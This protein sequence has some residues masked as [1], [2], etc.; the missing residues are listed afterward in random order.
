[1]S[2]FRMSSINQVALSG[3]LVQNPEARQTETGCLLI[4]FPIAV[5]LHYTDA[6]GIWQK[7]ITTVPVCASGKLA[8]LVAERLHQ[9]K[10][11]FITGR[12]Q[13]RGTGLEVIAR[14]IQLLNQEMKPE[15]A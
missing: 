3:T 14:H 4:T 15:E 7:E 10:A 12:L 8:E 11:V 13:F 9:G 2:T 5:N 6:E 1:M